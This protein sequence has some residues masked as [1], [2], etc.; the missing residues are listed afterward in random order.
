[1]HVIVVGGGIAGIAA[2]WKLRKSGAEV[3]LVEAKN[4]LG[5]RLSS[6]QREGSPTLFDGGPHLFLS[7][8]TQTRQLLRELSLESHFD[9]PYP[10]RIPFINSAGSRSS[11]NEWLLPAPL[12]LIGGLLSFSLLSWSARKR[13]F[14]TATNLI[15]QD[16]KPD[17]SI[18]EFL[19]SSSH[20]EEI[21]LFWKP[22]VS[23]ALNASVKEVAVKDLRTIFTRGFCGG[24]FG[25]RLGYANEPLRAIFS[26]GLL[27]S[28][29]NR[30]IRVLLKSPIA[31]IQHEGKRITGVIFQDGSKLKSD[32]I[33]SALPPWSLIRLS[34]GD[35][36]LIEALA[37]YRLDT[38]NAH[39]ISTFY[40]WA[41]KRPVLELYTCLPTSPTGWVFDFA[42]LW[43]HPDAP[44]GLMLESGTLPKPVE[45]N[46][47]GLLDGVY[48]RIPELQNVRWVGEKLICERHATPLRPQTLWGKKL[49]QKTSIINLVLSGDWID[50]SLPPT[51]EA[52]VNSGNSAA[53]IL[54]RTA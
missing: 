23:A 19:A 14:S 34:R 2:A 15:R 45:G 4:Y 38:W 54:L 39:P 21:D 44:L 49:N 25:G 41:E 26:D 17:Q 13:T 24:L 9:F 30:G 22:L 16:L 27:P 32:R 1:M 33:I 51:V 29:T 10:G 11:L 48:Q 43:N 35:T 3:T 53:E 6:F 47:R 28:L 7:S 5:G 42:R 31:A 37:E 20:P 52:A 40:L 36:L 50:E 12:N 8:Y 18:E 46:F